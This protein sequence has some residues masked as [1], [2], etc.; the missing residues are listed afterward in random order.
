MKKSS[1]A[2]IIILFL[3]LALI[4]GS[5]FCI[6]AAAEDASS[7]GKF[8]GISVA[9]GDKVAI[10]VAV[11]A[12]EEQIK[13]GEVIVS[14]AMGGKTA[15]ATYYTTDD[16]GQVWVITEGIA[17]F[18]LAQIVTFSSYVGGTAVESNRVYSVAQFLYKM[19]Y[20]DSGAS[21]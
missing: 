11:N 17:A 15:D 13:N 4:I 8:G 14:Y 21:E 6:S 3:S 9:Y 16:N 20:T 12:T 18:D 7:I 10:R 1:N 2:R 19:L 5:V